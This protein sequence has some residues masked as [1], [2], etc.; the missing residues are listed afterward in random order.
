M[1]RYP[2]ARS[3]IMSQTVGVPIGA[4]KKRP[5]TMTAPEFI[6]LNEQAIRVTSWSRDNATGAIEFVVIAKGERDRDQLLDTFAREPVM[7]R[8]GTGSAIPMDVR[9]LDTRSTGEGPRS[10]YRLEIVLWPEGTIAP[11]TSPAEVAPTASGGDKLDRIIELLSEIRD[12]IRR[13]R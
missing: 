6:Y 9:T 8:I 12:D 3:T 1:A 10:I 13:F 11:T 2:P 4:E 7:V 5:A